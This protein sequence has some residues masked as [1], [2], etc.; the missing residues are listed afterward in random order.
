MLNIPRGCRLEEEQDW[1]G[2]V[3]PT[4]SNFRSLED[5]RWLSRGWI[6]QE[7]TASSV[8]EF[9]GVD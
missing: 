2:F 8:V 5:S 3:S 6:L 1:F 4:L 9:C 7:H